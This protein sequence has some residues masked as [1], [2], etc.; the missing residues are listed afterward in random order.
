MLSCSCDFD[1]EKWYCY[2][3]DFETFNKK[4]R[5]RCCS[6]GKLIDIGSGCVRF[7]YYREPLTDIEERIMGDEVQLADQFMCQKCGEIYFNLTELGYCIN[8]GDE[9]TELMSE[10]WKLTGFKV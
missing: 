4:R 2:P 5:K 7:L 6:C 1:S 3:E 9:M 10:Y 8:L